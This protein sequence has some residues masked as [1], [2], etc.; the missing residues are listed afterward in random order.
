M[1]CPTSGQL[2]LM[3]APSLLPVRGWLEPCRQAVVQP[4]ED[5][6]EVLH[7]LL[8]VDA[9]LGVLPAEA[10]PSRPIANLVQRC[11]RPILREAAPL[12]LLSPFPDRPDSGVRLTSEPLPA[13]FHTLLLSGGSVQFG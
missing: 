13:R 10:D 3:S 7:F 8:D 6:E 2:L 5:V 11:V 1:I 9:E 12:V 4:V